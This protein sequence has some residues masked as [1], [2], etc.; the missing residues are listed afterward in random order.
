MTTS[1]F[2]GS[3]V[4]WN[5]GLISTCPP[6]ALLLLIHFKYFELIGFTFYEWH[7]TLR[8]LNLDTALYK[9]RRVVFVMKFGPSL[10]YEL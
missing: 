8:A 4:P 6:L 5:C 3:Q 10:N 7:C 1:P 2:V 9:Q